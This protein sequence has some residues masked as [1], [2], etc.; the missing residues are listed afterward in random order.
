MKK[1]FIPKAKCEVV[2]ENKVFALW[3]ELGKFLD[4]IM[5][6]WRDPHAFGDG[7]NT[8]GEKRPERADDEYT[9]AVGRIGIF[10]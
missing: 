8:D 4:S 2:E 10:P 7:I 9:C 3:S 5:V 6:L 1:G